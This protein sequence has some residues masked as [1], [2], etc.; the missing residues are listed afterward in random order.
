MNR[1]KWRLSELASGLMIS[2]RFSN[3][4]FKTALVIKQEK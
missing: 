4:P 1:P 3:R 2:A